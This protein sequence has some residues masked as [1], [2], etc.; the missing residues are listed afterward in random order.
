M[1]IKLKNVSKIYNKYSAVHYS[2]KSM[3]LGY[4][5]YKKHVIEGRLSVVK[6]LSL[7]IDRAEILGVIGPNG[8]GKST[9]AKLLAGITPPTKGTIEING[10]VIP[11]LELGVAFNIELK[12]VDNLYI[13]GSLLGLRLDFLKQNKQKIFQFAELEGFMQTPLKYYS[14]GMNLRLAFSIAMHAQGDIF[15]FDEILS[16]GDASFQKK[17]S[18]KFNELIRDKKTIIIITHDLEFIK[19]YSTKVFIMKKEDS[20]IITDKAKI[21]NL[22]Y[23]DII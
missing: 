8:A 1:M 5:K 21:K 12:A 4:K 19:K 22:T 13:N 10:K 15:V 18:K 9:L 20:F 7:E 23:D 3:L 17:C 2:L 14:S 6:N 16:V 11:F